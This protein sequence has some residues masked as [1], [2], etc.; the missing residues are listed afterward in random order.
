AGEVLGWVGSTG[1]S[2]GSH[3]HYTVFRYG[4]AVDPMPYLDA[5]AA[6]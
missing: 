5:L 3:L 2:T 6:R 1:R 4:V